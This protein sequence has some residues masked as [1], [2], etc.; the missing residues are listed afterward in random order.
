MRGASN[1]ILALLETRAEQLAEHGVFTASAGNFSQ[2]ILFVTRRLGLRCTV[3]VPDHTPPAKLEAMRRLDPDVVVLRC[4]FQDWFAFLMSEGRTLP[5]QLAGN[6]AVRG[7]FVS[8]IT[9]VDVMDGNGTMALEILEQLGGAAASA[10]VDAVLVPWGGGAMAVGIAT[11]LREKAPGLPVYACEVSTAA[12][13]GPSLAAGRQALQKERLLR[14][15]AAPRAAYGKRGSAWFAVHWSLT[16]E[17]FPVGDRSP[18][19]SALHALFCR[20]HR[21]LDCGGRH[22]APC[23]GPPDRRALRH[24]RRHR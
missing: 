17:C 13:V 6:A 1:A 22:V 24:T 2:G 18:R 23:P 12:P 7:C 19:S 21:R 11:V 8:P 10:D 4:P 20:R 15:A 3:L 9:C 14:G 16:R 5:P